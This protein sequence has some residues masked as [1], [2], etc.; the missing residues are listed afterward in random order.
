MQPAPQR[1]GHGP[2]K[3]Q[4]STV[5]TFTRPGG[6]GGGP[7]VCVCVCVCVCVRARRQPINTTCLACTCAVANR[8]DVWVPEST[9][10]DF[11]RIVK[12]NGSVNADLKTSIQ[13]SRAAANSIRDETRDATYTYAK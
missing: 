11:Q 13:Y 5:D 2:V 10:S 1:A 9:R 3:Q 6:G 12:R 4:Q 8:P 7:L